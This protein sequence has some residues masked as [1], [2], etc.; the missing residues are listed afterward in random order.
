MKMLKL[1]W[2]TI[3]WPFSAL[4]A[5]FF[6]VIFTPSTI[7]YCLLYTLWLWLRFLPR[8]FLWRFWVRP[9]GWLCLKSLGQWVEIK[10]EIPDPANGPYLFLP[11]H[12]S[13]IDAFLT[14]H[15]I[16]L[17]ITALGSAKY[18]KLPIWGWMMKA[19]GVLP[20]DN[21]DHERALA[22]VKKAEEA[23]KNGESLVIFPEGQ[24]SKSGK[25]QKFKKGAFHLAKNTD[26]TI[27]PCIISGAYKSWRRGNLMVRPGIV[28]FTFLK[29]IS[30]KEYENLSV[31]ELKDKLEAIMAE[32]VEKKGR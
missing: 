17:R 13:F 7:V 28:S 3:T 10:G 18:F 23:I 26:V 15:A 20:V 4:L 22:S 9:C 8:E 12:L 29:P 16:P 5:L 14:A 19:H 25:L 11:N 27:I 32:A 6:L 2:Q 24:R 21:K 30:A 1:I 31:V